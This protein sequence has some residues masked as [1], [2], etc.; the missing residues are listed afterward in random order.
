MVAR[1]EVARGVVA[2]EDGCYG[3]R[4]L[5]RMVAREGGC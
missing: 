4:L 1:G 2:R 5:G 3:G